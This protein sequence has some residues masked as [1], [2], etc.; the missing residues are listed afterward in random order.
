MLNANGFLEA[1]RVHAQPF[2]VTEKGRRVESSNEYENRHFVIS[3]M[4]FV[5]I[6]DVVLN[7]FGSLNAIHSW[8]HV[9]HD[10]VADRLAFHDEVSCTVE[11]FLSVVG[12]LTELRLAKSFHPLL[13]YRHVRKLVFGDDNT[14]SC[15]FWNFI[16]TVFK[17][18]RQF[19][20]KLFLFSRPLDFLL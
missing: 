5:P 2:N 4:L 16:L 7:A 6:L 8:H 1:V 19:R 20:I 15:L 9:V 10:Y 12:E 14:P 17:L 18:S 13:H 3:L 11:R